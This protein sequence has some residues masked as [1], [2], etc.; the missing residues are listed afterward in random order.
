M[1][2]RL[3]NAQEGVKPD[4]LTWLP[5]LYGGYF[6]KKKDS[7][8]TRSATQPQTIMEIS[9]WQASNSKAM[10]FY[11]PSNWSIYTTG[12]YKLDLGI[13]TNKY[14]E[15]TYNGGISVGSYSS[16]Y[17]PSPEP[18]PPGTQFRYLPPNSEPE[19]VI[20]YYIPPTYTS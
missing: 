17:D 6:N 5:I 1:F 4:T 11:N 9:L 12:G 2:L 18:Y 7:A 20:V 8:V 3:T 10:Q 19:T 15:L 13:H 16:Y 14:F